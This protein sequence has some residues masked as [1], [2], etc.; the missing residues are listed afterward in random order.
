MTTVSEVASEPLLK[1]LDLRVDVDG[2]PA[3]DGLTLQTRGERVLVLG[4][5]R[6]VFEATCALRP[7]TRGLLEVRGALA[8]T[9]VRSG[10]IAGAPLDPPLPPKW[11]SLEY[12]TWSS[13]LAGHTKSDARRL[14]AEAIALVQLGP[15]AGGTIERM[16]PHARRGVVLAAALATG[17]SVIALEDP[18]AALPEEIARA[19]AKIIVQ[20]LA[21]RSWIVFGARLPLTSPLAMNADEALMVSSSRLDAQG[22]PAEIAAQGRCFV[23]RIHSAGPLEKL[24][25]RLSEQGAKMDVQGAQVLLDLGASMTT[26][27]LLG[28]CAELDATVVEMVPVA[29]ALS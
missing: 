9:A 16:L 28:L 24:G 5:P 12:I 21:E 6:V 15:L 14:A 18:L 7:V 2:V 10:V 23:A 20:A 1:V 11:T 29:R 17:A 3:C 19:W 4:A 13:R 25:A 26:A 27:E 22:P 8:E